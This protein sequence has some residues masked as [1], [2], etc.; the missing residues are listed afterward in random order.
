MELA[1]KS[2]LAHE[3]ERVLIYESPA[4]QEKAR[5]VLPI[6]EMHEQARKNLSTVNNAV[7][8]DEKPLDFQ[9]FIFTTVH[10]GCFFTYILT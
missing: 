7:G 10:T 3:F 5:Q 4:L 1:V 9:V 2:Q 8:K 6:Q